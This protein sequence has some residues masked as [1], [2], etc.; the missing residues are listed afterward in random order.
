MVAQC[1][2]SCTV[3]GSPVFDVFSSGGLCSLQRL[4]SPR[5][6]ILFSFR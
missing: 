1:Y 4:D 3:E 2:V 6:D 5:P